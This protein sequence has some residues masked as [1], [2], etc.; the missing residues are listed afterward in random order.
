MADLVQY[1]LREGVA[2]LSLDDGKANAISHAMLDAVNGALDRAEKEAGAVLI[3][4]RPGRFSAGFDLSVMRSGGAAV[5]ELVGGGAR[6][7]LRLYEFPSPVVAA[8]T[9]H[10]LA[11]GAILLLASDTRLGARG[12]FKL[13]LNEVAI[14]M[15]L[16]HF[17]VELARDRLSKRHF[18]R[19]VAEAEIYTPEGAVD[20]GFLDRLEAPEALLDAAQ[21]EAERLAQLSRGAHHGTKLAM[22]RET[23]ERVREALDREMR[24]LA[25]PGR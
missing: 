19:A 8:C 20:A 13:G 2:R 15:T 12:D 22:R 16:P 5:G 6:L 14:G 25:G 9:G 24:G 10:A 1:E 3:A 21:A 7:A 11:M 17:G 18:T 23:I 4:G